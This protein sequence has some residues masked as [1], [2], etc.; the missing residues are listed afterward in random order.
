MRNV[1]TPALRRRQTIVL[2]LFIV[3][4]IFALASVVGVLS[5]IFGVG[6]V[7]GG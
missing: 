2:V 4:A 6:G 7:D 1:V 3:S 5:S